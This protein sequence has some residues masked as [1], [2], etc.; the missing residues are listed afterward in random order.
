[1]SSLEC[2]STKRLQ[3]LGRP[4]SLPK[5]LETGRERVTEDEATFT[6]DSSVSPTRPRYV[7][8]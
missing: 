1:M 6:E 8:T 5:A 2:S 3:T 4:K 7:F